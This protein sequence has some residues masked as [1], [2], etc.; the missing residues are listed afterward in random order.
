MSEPL[1]GERP[2]HQNAPVVNTLAT[3]LGGNY[4]NRSISKDTSYHVIPQVPRSIAAV[5]GLSRGAYYV[6]TNTGQLVPILDN[7]LDPDRYRSERSD[8]ITTLNSATFFSRCR[9]RA[10]HRDS[11]RIPRGDAKGTAVPASATTIISR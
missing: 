8:R 10:S 5:A 3:L 7:R 2:R 9:C 1:Q 6:P 11:R 4:V